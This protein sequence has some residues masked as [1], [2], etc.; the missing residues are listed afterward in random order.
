M[1]HDGVR[2]IVD[3]NIFELARGQLS[4]ARHGSR[5]PRDRIGQQLKENF[6]LITTKIESF[7]YTSLVYSLLALSLPLN[8]LTP[9][10]INFWIQYFKNSIIYCCIHFCA[11]WCAH[12][13]N[14]KR[15]DWGHDWY[16]CVVFY[17]YISAVHRYTHTM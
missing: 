13:T 16:E 10:F 17:I 3:Y 1:G 2:N 9:S 11:E 4:F 14:E 8:P 5:N 6:A 15:E 7:N 12:T